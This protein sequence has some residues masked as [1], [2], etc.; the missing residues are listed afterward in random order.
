MDKLPDTLTKV[1]DELSHR[2]GTT[3]AYL[4]QAYVKYVQMPALGWLIG[5]MIGSLGLIVLGYKVYQNL[6][7]DK[8]FVEN[9][10]DTPIPFF[11]ACLVFA[12][13]VLFALFIGANWADVFAPQGAAVYYILHGNR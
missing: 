11:C 2:F 4:W 5:G 8:T 6:P 7:A 1:L 9:F 12:G 3:G 13:V 10:D